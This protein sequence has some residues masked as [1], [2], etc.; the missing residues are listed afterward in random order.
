[1]RLFVL[2]A[3][4]VAA[5]AAAACSPS[6]QAEVK[7]DVQEAADQVKDAARSVAN[8]PDIKEAGQALKNVA[9]DAGA[10]VKDAAAEVKAASRDAAAD[11]KVA[12]QEAA[13]KTKRAAAAAGDAAREEMR[14]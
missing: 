4:A 2:A 5:F 11:A 12:T 1:M 14:K 13:D 3:V 8:D 10:S 9:A 7:A 6:D